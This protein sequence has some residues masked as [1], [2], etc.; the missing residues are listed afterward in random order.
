M[1]PWNGIDNE[2][3]SPEKVYNR[4]GDEMERLDQ[5]ATEGEGLSADTLPGSLGGVGFHGEPVGVG[6]WEKSTKGG[7]GVRRGRSVGSIGDGLG[8]A[9]RL[10]QVFCCRI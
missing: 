2:E 3:M 10:L 8:R 7:M 1:S 5:E 4:A 9:G 6:A